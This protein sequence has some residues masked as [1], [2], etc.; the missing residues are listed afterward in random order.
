MKNLRIFIAGVFLIFGSLAFSQQA[1]D[2]SDM[3]GAEDDMAAMAEEAKTPP[4]ADKKAM[5]PATQEPTE[6]AEEAVEQTEELKKDLK[7]LEF[8]RLQA[9]NSDRKNAQDIINSVNTWEILYPDSEK[10]EIALIL[11]A[12]LYMKLRDYPSACMSLVK[13][14]YFNIG[15]Q[16]GENVKQYLEGC[17]NK[18]DRKKKDEIL[19]IAQNPKYIENEDQSYFYLLEQI[20][21][22]IPNDMYEPL[23][24]EFE[25]FLRRHPNYERNDKL[26]LLFG[27]LHRENKNYKAAM[28]QYQKVDAFYPESIYR[29]ASLRLVG[30]VYAADLRNQEEAF[31]YYRRVINEYP[32]SVE[33]PTAYKH[34]AMVAQDNRDY[35]TALRI[36][37]EIIE[38]YKKSSEVLFSYQQKF[39]IYTRIKDYRKALEVL[40]AGFETYKDESERAIKF[41]T[42]ASEFSE[43]YLRDLRLSTN[44]LLKITETYPDYYENPRLIYAAAENY[45]K[46]K[47]Y[48]SAAIYYQK[49]IDKYPSSSYTDDAKK[50]LEKITSQ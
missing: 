12:D 27:D 16:Y 39:K 45:E 11:K 19:N 15:S 28:M 46:I 20:S 18:L 4:A 23:K 35:E 10:K 50:R 24:L 1:D 42:K 33:V 9:M 29:A 6:V 37:D 5:K 13:H 32:D 43:K 48:D 30:D 26:E 40:D 7:F 14:R 22:I 36:Y 3:I 49:V 25:N 31:K 44:Y 8:Y 47:D 2:V 17:L 41:L 34:M 21:K 38:K